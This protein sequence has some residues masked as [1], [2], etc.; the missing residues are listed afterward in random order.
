MITAEDLYKTHAEGLRKF[1]FMKV[2]DNDQAK[3]LVQDT[4]VKVTR[5][6]HKF[7]GEC[8]PFTWL[9]K[10]ALNTLRSQYSSNKTDAVASGKLVE[11]DVIDYSITERNESPLDTLLRKERLLQLEER[12]NELNDYEQELLTL[13]IDG[14]SQTEAEL[15][16]HFGVP[17]GT[18]KSRTYRIRLKMKENNGQ[19]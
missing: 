6:V 19:R 17:L 11:E 9:C 10:I 12:F 7:R 16:I 13:L 1:L 14:D 8:K 3:D 2:R 5:E 4:F 15:A 18:I